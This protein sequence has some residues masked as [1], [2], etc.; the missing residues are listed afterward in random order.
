[1]IASAF[2]FAAMGATVKAASRQLPN[3]MVVFFRNLLGLAA[4][5]P[6][7]PRLGRRG[8]GTA[9]LREHLIRGLAGLASMYCFFY[10][11]AHLRLA[12][13]M[14]LNY[15]LP[16][17]MPF[18]EK[19]WLGEQ[20]PREVW[21]ALAIGFLGLFLILR[22][23]PGVFNPVALVGVASAVLAALA[24]VGVR[25][26]TRTEPPERIVFYF[27]VV[28]TAVSALPLA[29]TWT[30]PPAA[31]WGI[32]ALMGVLATLG[33]L[34]LTRA[35]SLAPAVQVGPFIYTSVVFAGLLDA[36]LWG[37]WPD[38]FFMAGAGLVC[39]AGILAL[40]RRRIAS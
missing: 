7:L 9:S 22:P 33:Q 34:M 8:L 12:E 20:T 29:R 24:Q 27:A 11:I 19:T 10:A 1:M 25:R 5:L 30:T 31:L 32:L 23:G 36:G 18:I 6:W 3:S 2:L 21:W 4:L 39:L 17:F 16:L 28:A 37:Q 26:L 38:A 13:A 35:Y 40:R 15:S 14:L